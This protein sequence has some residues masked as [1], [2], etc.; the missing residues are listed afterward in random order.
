MYYEIRCLSIH[1]HNFE[2]IHIL[3]LVPN[4]LQKAKIRKKG[5]VWSQWWARRS[6]NTM[7]KLAKLT[8]CKIL[9]KW[10]RTSCLAS[11]SKDFN[12]NSSPANRKISI[13]VKKALNSWSLVHSSSKPNISSNL[14]SSMLKIS[15]H[16]T[17]WLKIQPRKSIEIWL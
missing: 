11:I 16:L 10:N 12:L 9:S 2:N 5:A 1:Y 6:S 15:P 14:A 13:P 17:I 3:Q 8:R 4:F 7:F